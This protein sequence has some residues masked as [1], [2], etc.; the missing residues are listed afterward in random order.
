MRRGEIAL[1]TLSA[2]NL[3]AL[4]SLDELENLSDLIVR[5]LDSL[6][7]YQDYPIEAAR[8]ASMNRRTL[9]VGVT[10][11]AYYLAK[12]GVRYSDGSANGLVHKTFEAVQYYLLKASNQL[13]KEQG[14]C[15]LFNET[16]YAKAFCRLIPISV[17]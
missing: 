4:E 11:F 8:T 12:N 7:D 15:K 17:K 1:C 13:A 14:P 16:N 6:L 2:F 9:G 5:A 3:G 10:N